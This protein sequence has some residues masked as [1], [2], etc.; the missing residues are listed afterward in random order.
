[1]PLV[2]LHRVFQRLHFAV[3][4]RHAVE[5]KRLLGV[6]L[7]CFVHRQSFLQTRQSTCMLPKTAQYCAKIRQIGGHAQAIVAL[8]IEGQG[9]FIMDKRFGILPSVPAEKS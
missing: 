7:R 1:M 6:M 3:N 2:L 5:R 9:R 8:P 4:I